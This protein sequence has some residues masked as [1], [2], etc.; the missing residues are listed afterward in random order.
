LARPRMINEAA[1]GTAGIN[2][3]LAT[4]PRVIL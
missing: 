1:S 2:Q 4:I 3:M